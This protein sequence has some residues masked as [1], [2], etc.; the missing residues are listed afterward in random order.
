MS[1]DEAEQLAAEVR[2]ACT[3]V[4]TVV[5]VAPEGPHRAVEVS[6]R[7]AGAQETFILYDRADWDWLK[8]RIATT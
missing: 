4:V 2:Q 3:D 6:R 8:D 5:P 1:Q 7:S